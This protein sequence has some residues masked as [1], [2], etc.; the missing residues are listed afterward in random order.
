MDNRTYQRF[1]RHQTFSKHQVRQCLEKLCSQIPIWSRNWSEKVLSIRFG[2]LM[3]LEL[4]KPKQIP[5]KIWAVLDKTVIKLSNLNLDLE[6]NLTSKNFPK[7]TA[8]IATKDFILVRILNKEKPIQRK[9]MVTY[10]VRNRVSKL[11]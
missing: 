9:W 6:W 8:I 5:S 2:L 4:K 10:M 3:E 11:S 1:L 7:M